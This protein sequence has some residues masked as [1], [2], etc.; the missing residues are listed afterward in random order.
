MLPFRSRVKCSIENYEISMIR[1]LIL[2]VSMTITCIC[3]SQTIN[4][5]FFNSKSNS[6]IEISKIERT[7]TNTIIHFVYNNQYEKGGWFNI[8]NE[9]KIKESYGSRS[10][11][12]IRA[13][14]AKLSPDKTYCD[15]VGQIFTFRLIFPKIASDITEIDLIE[16]S[17]SNCFNF[18]G[19]SL[20]SKT[21]ENESSIFRRDYNYFTLYD[22]STDSWGE[23]SLGNNTF[24]L[25]YNSNNDI[26]HYQ[27]NGELVV[28]RRISDIEEAYTSTGEHYQ[29][30]TALDGNGL[31]FQFQFFDN[32]SIGLKLIYGD[33]MIQFAN[34]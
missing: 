10:Y 8:N 21:D 22:R 26:A 34:F 16:C 24:V 28:Y 27:G 12:V 31:R 13:E 18:Y 33:V 14:G 1:T 30:L 3:V 7:S 15:Y 2:L 5:P 11:R 17:T 4:N 20:K 19:V 25:N 23:W 29:I 9:M 32:V 6:A